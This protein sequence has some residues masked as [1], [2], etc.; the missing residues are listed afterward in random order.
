MRTGRGSRSRAPFAT[1]A[2]VRA[3]ASAPALDQQYD[4]R[5]YGNRRYGHLEGGTD[6]DGGAFADPGKRTAC[7]HLPAFPLQ[8]LLRRQNDFRG[9]PAAVVDRDHPQGRILWANEEARQQR[10]LP[11]HR[12]AAALGICPELRAA[13][14]PPEEIAAGI[15]ELTELLLRFTPAVE[16]AAHDPGVFWLDASGLV[17]L[18]PSLLEWSERLHRTLVAE[19]LRGG[20][21]CGFGRFATY[22]LAHVA[23]SAQGG[24]GCARLVTDEAEERRLVTR[25]PLERLEI[26]PDLREALVRLGVR[27]VGDLLRLPPEGLATRFGKEAERLHRTARGELSEPLTACIPDEPPTRRIAFH[28]MAEKDTGRLLHAI[29]DATPGLVAETASRNQALAALH[30]RLLLEGAAPRLLEARPAAPTLDATQVLELLRLQIEATTKHRGLGRGVE[31]IVLT[32]RGVAARP[33]QLRLF[34]ENPRRDLQAAARALARLRAEHGPYAVVTATLT[35]G[36]LPEASFALLPLDELHF[37]TPAARA[38]EN[39]AALVRRLLTRP[40]LLPPRPRHEPDGWLLAGMESGPVRR[41]VGPYLLAGAWWGRGPEIGT[42]IGAQGGGAACARAE[43]T[44]IAATGTTGVG[45]HREYHFAE[46]AHGDIFWVF[47]D[48]RRRRW[49]LQGAVE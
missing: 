23:S 40:S 45:I 8:L 33:E 22:A 13:E 28:E 41:S 49:Y 20:V 35:D 38:A 9:V 37:P 27:T 30:V 16:P 32:V 34:R 39:P 44:G 21:V 31:E 12:Y 17:R 46:T 10:V 25:V 29:E 6:S 15:V 14:V 19:N 3:H 43:A 11:G 42:G 48:R 5:R 7:V 4:D 1:P 24:A 26:A 36:H 2:N 18:H 47:H